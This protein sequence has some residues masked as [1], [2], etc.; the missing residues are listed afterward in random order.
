MITTS[1]AWKNLIQTDDILPESNVNVVCN[2]NII[3]T[4]D[5]ALTTTEKTDFSNTS[6][7]NIYKNTINREQKKIGTFE[8]NM[9]VL[10][11]S[12]RFATD[13][14]KVNRFVSNVMSDENGNFAE[15]SYPQVELYL[16]GTTRPSM[17]SVNFAPFG[18]FATNIELDGVEQTIKEYNSR[19]V[20]LDNINGGSVGSSVLTIKSWSMPYRRARVSE[21]L[22]GARI[23]FDKTNFSKFKH[24][25][26]GDMINAAL[27]QNDCTFS[28]LDINSDYDID[29]PNAKFS[30]IIDTTSI[31]KVYYGYKI[32]NAWEYHLIDTLILASFERP[33]NGI[34]ASFVLESEINRMTQTF[35]SDKTYEFTSYDGLRYLIIDTTGRQIDRYN[36]NF[37][38]VEKIT[39][40]YSIQYALKSTGY[41]FQ[42][43]MNEMLQ[44]LASLVNC[45]IFNNENGQQSIRSKYDYETNVLTD[46]T[47]LDTI[48][49]D[50]C[51]EYPEIERISLIEQI[52]LTLIK[53]PPSRDED[54]LDV[55]YTDENGVVY[56]PQR[57]KIT[58]KDVVGVQETLENNLLVLGSTGT[59]KYNFTQA[60]GI[61][62]SLMRWVNL[63]IS[64]ARKIRTKMRIN[65]AWQIGDLISIELK[66]GTYANGY[67]IDIDIDY[68]GYSKGYVTILAPKS[69]N[70]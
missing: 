20:Y 24:V 59:E 51:L 43:P 32:N 2:S 19:Y 4:V 5:Y 62:L 63:F 36:G 16:S 69:L 25:R 10:D 60:D 65:P 54:S 9:W 12:Y 53:Y 31:F 23:F 26:N 6:Y 22:L 34:E 56:P 14:E 30:N 66:N 68:Q 39:L 70:S 27:P 35:T 58:D 28:V 38:D 8:W 17:Y 33:Q 50:N 52:T 49:L 47:I 11:G 13:D 21:F 7:F 40:Y 61:Y 3:D 18:G 15:D 44:Q 45:F 42:T 37:A 41:F 67:I 57:Y 46:T 1:D 48:T 55:D 29:N 64:G